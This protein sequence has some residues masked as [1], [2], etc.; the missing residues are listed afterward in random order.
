MDLQKDRYFETLSGKY[1][2]SSAKGDCPNNDDSEGITLESL[3]ECCIISCRIVTKINYRRLK[4]VM[5][6]ISNYINN[7]A[8]T[9]DMFLKLFTLITKKNIQ[10]N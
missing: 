5:F 10:D 6:E 7:I 4:K 9:K 1:W 8:A 2:N 3:G